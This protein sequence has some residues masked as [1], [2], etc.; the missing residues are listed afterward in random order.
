[1]G[2]C[3]PGQIPRV[4]FGPRTLCLGSYDKKVQERIYRMRFGGD[5]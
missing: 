5:G 2:F 3:S 1:M 4:F